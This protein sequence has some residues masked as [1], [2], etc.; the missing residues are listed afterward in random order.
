MEVTHEV[1]PVCALLWR[2][3]TWCTRHQVTLK[4]RHIPDLTYTRSDIKLCKLWCCKSCTFC[5]RAFPK[6]RNKS[7]GSSLSNIRETQI[8]ICETCFLCHSLVLCPTCNKC[9]TCCTKSACR[10]QTTTLLANLAGSRSRSESYP[11][12]ERGLHPPLPDPA[13]TYK[14]SHGHKLLCQSSQ[15]QL[16]VGGITST[17]RQKRSGTG[18]KPKF[19][20]VFQPTLPGTKTQQQTMKTHIGPKQTKCLSQGGEIQNGNT[21]NHQ[22]FSPPGGMGHLHRFQG[23]L[24][25]HTNTRTL[26]EVS[27]V[28]F[29]KPNIPVQGSALWSLN[30]TFGIH[31]D[32][33][34]GETNGHTQGYKDPPVPRRLVGESQIPPG[35]SPTYSGPS[36]NVPGSRLDGELGKVSTAAKTNLRFCRLPV[37]P[38]GRSSPTYTGPVAEPPGHYN[39]DSV[40]TGLSGPTVHVLDRPLNSHRK[41]S[42][43]RQT[44][45]ETL[46]NNWQVPNL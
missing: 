12:S 13:K 42:S 9:P 38:H 14:V 36:T 32:S 34:R 29:P 45:H 44:A 41:T 31:C 23:R 17:Y 19:P 25:P 24:L 37:R 39:Q 33:Q 5:A 16:P 43:P 7:R 40:V 35:L 27:Q 30:G 22:S 20:R 10:G 3:L 28:S 8:K 18:A 2:M 1:G 11:D 26:Q 6:E 15:G 46:E 4:A 21:R